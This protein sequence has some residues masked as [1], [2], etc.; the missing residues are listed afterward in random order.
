MQYKT[1]VITGVFALA[2]NAVA[3][4]SAA[5]GSVKYCPFNALSG[6]QIGTWCAPQKRICEKTY[7]QS[8]VDCVAV[9]Q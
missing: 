6:K 4:S 8:T 1:W 9:T 2:L 7:P 5:A 3:A